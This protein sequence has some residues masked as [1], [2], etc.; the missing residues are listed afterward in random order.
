MSRF[1]ANEFFQVCWG[2]FVTPVWWSLHQGS[3]QSL[4]QE[5]CINRSIFLERQVHQ[6]LNLLSAPSLMGLTGKKQYYKPYICLFYKQTPSDH[7]CAKCTKNFEKWRFF[8]LHRFVVNCSQ[9]TF[10]QT[11]TYRFYHQQGTGKGEVG[12]RMQ[13]TGEGE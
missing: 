1:Q 13:S 5:E 6:F 7:Q 4:T 2:C 9:S 12:S 10:C 3:I 11:R 8:K